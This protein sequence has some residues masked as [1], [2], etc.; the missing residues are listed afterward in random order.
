MTIFSL[1]FDLFLLRWVNVCVFLICLGKTN[2]QIF[3]DTHVLCSL[4]FDSWVIQYSF[5]H[6]LGILLLYEFCLLFVNAFAVLPACLFL[7]P[8]Q[9]NTILC[10]DCALPSNVLDSHS[11]L[12]LGHGWLITYEYRQ[13]IDLYW[14]S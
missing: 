10:T 12:V 11:F 2:I 6:T 3:T 7:E 5:I 13:F 1:K 4:L 9:L 8:R 14:Y